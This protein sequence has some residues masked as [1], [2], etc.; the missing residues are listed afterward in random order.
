MISRRS[1][2]RVDP[3]SRGGDAEPLGIV[4]STVGRSPLTRGRPPKEIAQIEQL[5]SIPAHAGETASALSSA[6]SSRVD[7]RSRG[8]DLAQA[9]GDSA[10]GGRSPLTRG[11]RAAHDADARSAG[12]IPA[13]AG[14]THSRM[15]RTVRRQVDPR[16]R[17]GDVADS[18]RYPSHQGRS[19]LT[20]GR[21]LGAQHG[22]GGRGSI[23]AHAGETWCCRSLLASSRVDPRSR[24]G[25][26][27]INEW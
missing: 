3:R 20:R 10:R 26:R 6:A 8:G 12:S 21:H 5:R 9:V 23:P 15:A 11:R 13:H 4:K 18:N 27:E 22:L 24:G 17:G 14:E 25:D 19:P 2:R 7:P 1:S 16:S